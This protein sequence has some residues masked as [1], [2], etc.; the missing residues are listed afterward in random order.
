[1]QARN[2]AGHTPHYTDSTEHRDW[3]LAREDELFENAEEVLP[4]ADENGFPARREKRERV[5][6]VA[7]YSPYP[8]VERDQR[9]LTAFV[10]NESL[11]GMCLVSDRDE[12][13]G[14][15]IR[16][17]VQAIDGFPTQERLARVVW[18]CE[19]ADGRHWL[20]LSL[21]DRPASRRM[22]TNRPQTKKAPTGS[23]R[24]NP[25]FNL[26]KGRLHRKAS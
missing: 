3:L 24:T 5:F 21:L 23:V 14:S 4:L 8:R 2:Q 17:G 18:T 13:V 16:V 26:I 12:P 10:R 11:S 19:Q 20:G 25:G 7:E 22:E 6:R 1:M 15:W 9:R